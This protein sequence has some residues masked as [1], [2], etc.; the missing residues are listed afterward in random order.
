MPLIKFV[1]SLKEDFTMMKNNDG[2]KID[3]EEKRII[4]L[5]PK[6]AKFFEDMKRCSNIMESIKNHEKKKLSL[7][8]LEAVNFTQDTVDE[9]QK[10]MDQVIKICKKK[11]QEEEKEAKPFMPTSTNPVTSQPEKKEI[12]CTCNN[13]NSNDQ[14]LK[15]LEEIKNLIISNEKERVEF[16]KQIVDQ[17]GLIRDSY[18]LLAD[19][20]DK[21]L[22]S[23]KSI[24]NKI[25]KIEKRDKSIIDAGF[26]I[27]ASLETLVRRSNYDEEFKTAMNEAFKNFLASKEVKK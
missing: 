19:I 20:L 16:D 8:D 21:K 12:G 18:S 26:Q 13:S 10:W 25:K 24:K 1:L 23:D 17:F 3:Y 9:I 4:L 15:S 6:F 7:E 14:I 11:L 22:E 5:D 2:F 27:L